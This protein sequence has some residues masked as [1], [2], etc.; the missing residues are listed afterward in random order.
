MSSLGHGW[1]ACSVASG[2]DSWHVRRPEQRRSRCANTSAEHPTLPWSSRMHR[3]NR[4]RPYRADVI[5]I[6]WS[7]CDVQEALNVSHWQYWTPS[8]H[9]TFKQLHELDMSRTIMV[10]RDWS[11]TVP[12]APVKVPAES[13][14]T[15][16]CHP[17][18]LISVPIEI[19]YTTSYELWSYLALF[20]RYCWFYVQNSNITSI[21]SEFWGI[22]LGPDCWCC[23]SEERR[24]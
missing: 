13:E 6:T 17:R 1:L 21:P 15:V 7:V 18:S 14:M 20:Q 23:G 5:K 4:I 12:P 11:K 22:P 8:K 10:Q 24:P 19:A 9:A 2:M 3:P 16:Q